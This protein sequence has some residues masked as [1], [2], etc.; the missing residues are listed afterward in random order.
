MTPMTTLKT[1]QDEYFK[2]VARVEEP[3]VKA[4]NRV[5]DSVAEYVPS[6]PAFMA[7]MPKIADVVDNQLRFRKR[8]VDEQAAFVRK[9]MKAMNPVVVKFE[10]VE[11]KKP[12]VK[13]ATHSTAT[14]MAPRSVGHKAA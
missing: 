8:F 4:T 10:H 9:M 1:W 11:A 3:V 2:L 12:A 7:E 14:R 6:R 13:A 5:A